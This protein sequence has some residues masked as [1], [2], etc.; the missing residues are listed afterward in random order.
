MSV[1]GWWLLK[2][3]VFILS[4]ASLLTLG[5]P[6]GIDDLVKLNTCGPPQIQNTMMNVTVKEGQEAT[7][8]CMIDMSKCMVSTIEWFHEMPNGTS[9]KIKTARTGDPHTHTIG[10][11]EYT[12]TGLYRCEAA[13][14]L[15]KAEASAYLQ[16]NSPASAVLP[17]RLCL[18]LFLVK[19]ATLL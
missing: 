14:V 6:L 7:F 18:T 2:G 9:R 12:H 8:K 4:V 5:A 1:G 17:I 19:A 16:V 11:A 10:K 13:S 15:G 3:E